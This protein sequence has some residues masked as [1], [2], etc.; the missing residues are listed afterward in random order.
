MKQLVDALPKMENPTSHFTL[1]GHIASPGQKH[2]RHSMRAA[3]WWLLPSDGEFHQSSHSLQYYLARQRRRVVLRGGDV[4]LPPFE[5]YLNCVTDPMPPPARRPDDLTSP[6]PSEN[7]PPANASRKLPRHLRP[8]RC[9]GK[10]PAVSANDNSAS[11]VA[12]LATPLG[13]SAN[14]NSSRAGS[15]AATRPRSAANRNLSIPGPQ[16]GTGSALMKHPQT[17]QSSQHSQHPRSTANRNS[18]PRSHLDHPEIWAG[19]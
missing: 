18:E 15:S 8:R 5:S 9:R 1:R 19:P 12:D 4:T 14:G 16:P 3:I 6:A 17:F 11:R 10:Q 13:P 2:L 7:M